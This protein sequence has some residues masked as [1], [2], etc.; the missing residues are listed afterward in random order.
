[1]EVLLESIGTFFETHGGDIITSAIIVV[2]GI[3]LIRL[4][5]NVTK[6]A[7]AKSPVS[8]TLHRFI[9]SMLNVLLYVV[10]GMTVLQVF[11]VPTTSILAAFS[12]IGLAISLSIQNS[13]ANVAGGV[14]LLFTKPFEVGDYIMFEDVE[15]TVDRISIMTTKIMTFDNK[16]IYI[17]NGN[18]T[19]DKIT[20]F[21]SAGTR[22]LD[23][24][25]SISY[26]NDFR[27]AIRLIEGLIQ[28]E[29]LILKDQEGKEP[30]VRMMEHGA[31][32]IVLTVKVW[33]NTDDY[34]PTRYNLL[35]N[36]KE[37]FDEHDISI[38]F[39]QM[40]IVLRKDEPN[41]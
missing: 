9:L 15:G 8:V 5:V 31:S 14:I 27:Q 4:T 25:V 1:M 12:V 18:L 35:E 19:Q 33:V 41:A 13:F 29:A 34:W 37:T 28:K 39:N 2:V 10:L 36:I 40:E 38:P 20:N 7:L 17:P 22:R 32:A 21:T 26:H 30:V 16:S 23:L 6:K 24:L 3:F 11:G